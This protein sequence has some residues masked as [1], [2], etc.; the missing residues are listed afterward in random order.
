DTV[1][2]VFQILIDP[3]ISLTS[4]ASI[5]EL[6]DHEDEDEIL[7]TTH[8]VFR[9]GEIRKI[10]NNL[11]LYEVDLKFTA[12]DDKQLRKLTDRI[13]QESE[14]PTGWCRLG[15]LL[16]KTGQFDKAEELYK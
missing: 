11:R 2:V 4:F 12:D 8:S 1:G 9:I 15:K 10:D 3:T 16:L 7:F 6:S 13:R 5:R 14:S